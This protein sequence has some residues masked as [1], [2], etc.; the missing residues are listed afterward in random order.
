MQLVN[1]RV[2]NFRCVEDSEDFGLDRVTCLV[3]KNEAGKSAL[4]ESL[5]RIKPHVRVSYDRDNDYPRRFLTDYSERHPDG[6]A[7]ITRTTWRLT[8][9]DREA[10]RA[11]IGPAADKVGD[12]EVTT[13]YPPDSSHIWNISVDEKVVATWLVEAA[14]LSAEDKAVVSKCDSVKALK[15][16]LGAAATTPLQDLKKRIDEVFKRGTA[17]L[18]AIDTLSPRMPTFV[19][20]SSYDLMRGKVHL[21][22]LL[23][24]KTANPPALID[25]DQLF[26]DFCEFAG[27]SIEE[28]VEINQFERLRAKFEGAQSKITRQIFDYWS[29]NRY[30]RVIFSRDA[31]L[32]GDAAPFNT[33]QVFNIRI[34]N[35]LH[36]STVSF[37]NRSAGFVWFFSFL[38]FFSQVRKRLGKN[39]ILLLDEP[40]LN[41]HAKAQSDLLRFI[42]EKLAPDHQ[43]IYST[44]SLFMVPPED[45]L[46]VRIVEDVIKE[47]E[48][49][50]PEVFG[51]KV[52]T[53]VLKVTKE[54]LFPLQGALGFEITQTLFV[55][56]NVLIV[57][58][59]SDLLYLKAFSRHLVES[60][61]KG[62]DQRWTICPVGGLDKVPAFLA[63]FHATN[64]NLAVLV[65]LAVGGKKKVA[66]AKKLAE[67]LCNGS[68]V[69]TYADILES[70]EA[71][72][73][74]ML[75]ST[76]FVE[77][78]SAAY[79]LSPA[80]VPP[81]APVARILKWTEE[82][83]RL[84][85]DGTDFD[86][87]GAAE[88]LM[89]NRAAAIPALTEASSI[90][91]RF[92]RLFVMLNALL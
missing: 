41:L 56:K 39:L 2:Q 92:E 70:S 36:E 49:G 29:S 24:R 90:V 83:M 74:D 76:G 16:T 26:I 6:K 66:E 14:K 23:A 47:R 54:T 61:R 89:Q 9:A 28:L 80:L 51:T 11:V 37:S 63:L 20:F 57:E 35:E 59:P 48:G 1:A 68:R 17:S 86:H 21:E 79:R 50:K 53:D 45:L 34:W 62:L 19:Y 69:F 84:R 77:L 55:G 60:G 4:L 3:G 91:D 52:R 12:V 82:Q 88:Y 31:A 7:D 72:V 27:S 67:H 33:G 10:L 58:G 25:G 71:D 46:S 87:Y 75:G 15:E 85:A 13:R 32:A 40:G 42:D 22:S 78:V 30:L 73:E 43:V 38:V 18:A 64:L 65:D 5:W 44:H 8:D 81:T